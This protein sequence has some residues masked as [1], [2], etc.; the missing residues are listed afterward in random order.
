MTANLPQ[1]FR[2]ELGNATRTASLDISLRIQILNR[3]AHRRALPPLYLPFW[4]LKFGNRFS[5]IF[6][7]FSSPKFC[8]LIASNDRRQRSLQSCRKI[9]SML[10]EAANFMR[11]YS[12]TKLVILLIIIFNIHLIFVLYFADFQWLKSFAQS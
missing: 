7:L 9:V 8:P 10:L 11:R 12:L 5:T 2:E 1:A 3:S 6:T 4:I